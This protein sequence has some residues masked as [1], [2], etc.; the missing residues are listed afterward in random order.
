MHLKHVAVYSLVTVASA[1][2]ELAM[3]KKPFSELGSFPARSLRREVS[4][5]GVLETNPYLL[6]AWSSGGAYYVNG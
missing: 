6:L 4:G 5:S 1:L 2:P 3:Q